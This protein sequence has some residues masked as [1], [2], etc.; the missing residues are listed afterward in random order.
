MHSIALEVIA[1]RKVDEEV[2]QRFC[3]SDCFD[4]D[5]EPVVRRSIAIGHKGEEGVENADGCDAVQSGYAEAYEPVL[6]P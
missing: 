3:D 6:G 1:V 2:E 4:E 5:W